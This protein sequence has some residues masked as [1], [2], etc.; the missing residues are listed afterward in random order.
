[1]KEAAALFSIPA[2]GRGIL[3]HPAECLLCFS[4]LENNVSLRSRS[5]KRM[6][7]RGDLREEWLSY[8]S[9]CRKR[10]ELFKQLAGAGC[11][12]VKTGEN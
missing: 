1:M 12:V 5:S 8:Q 6:A 3:C 7:E 10:V 4:F 2:T 9:G 11:T